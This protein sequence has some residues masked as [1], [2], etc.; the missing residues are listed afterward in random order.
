MRL[1]AAGVAL[2][3]A[4]ALPKGAIAES[5]QDEIQDEEAPG[6]AIE[7]NIERGF[8]QIGRQRYLRPSPIELEGQSLDVPDDPDDPVANDAVDAELAGQ[9]PE[10]LSGPDDDDPLPD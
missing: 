4:A 8:L 2:L 6:S 10:G 7:L 5:L 1:L 9:G 3:L